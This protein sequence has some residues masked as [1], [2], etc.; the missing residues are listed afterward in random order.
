MGLGMRASRDFA[1]EFRLIGITGI[2]V[3]VGALCSGV[4][5]VLLRLIDLFTNLFYFQQ[6][7]LVPRSPANHTLSS[8]SNSTNRAV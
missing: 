2:A 8:P 4:A 1:A 7:S 5:Y 6:L 3:V